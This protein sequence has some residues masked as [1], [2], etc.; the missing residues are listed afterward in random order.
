MGNIKTQ[1]HNKRLFNLSN[2]MDFLQI[3]FGHLKLTSATPGLSNPCKLRFKSN[4]AGI[5]KIDICRVVGVICNFERTDLLQIHRYRYGLNGPPPNFWH[6]KTCV[7]MS[8]RY[9]PILAALS[10]YRNQ[11]TS[12]NPAPPSTS[13]LPI[14]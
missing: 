5:F 6:S 11:T 13:M 8:R 7:T 2:V 10:N 12:I 1:I 14:I 9:G 4:I 3:R